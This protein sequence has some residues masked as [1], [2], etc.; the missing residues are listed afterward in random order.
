MFIE[1]RRMLPHTRW[2]AQE[3]FGG[4]TGV[5][6]HAELGC[7]W[8]LSA[9]MRAVMLAAE[10]VCPW[11]VVSPSTLP[12]PPAHTQPNHIPTDEAQRRG[13]ASVSCLVEP[14]TSGNRPQKLI[15]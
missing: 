10:D 2:G 5:L 12:D 13:Q 15:L 9:G 7:K 6:Q 4:R 11:A 14:R 1:A 3:D 8:V